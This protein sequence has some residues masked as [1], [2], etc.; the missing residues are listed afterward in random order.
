MSTLAMLACSSPATAPADKPDTSSDTGQLSDAQADGQGVDTI[1]GDDSVATDTLVGDGTGLEDTLPGTD[2]AT[3]GDADAGKPDTSTKDGG[4]DSTGSPQ[5]FKSLL[6]KILGP[7][8]RDW[9]QSGGAAIQLTGAAFGSP[10]SISWTDA[11]GGTGKITPGEYWKSGILTLKPG[12]NHYTVTATKGTATVSDTVH[13]VYNPVFQFDG[14][15]EITPNVLFVNE[16]SNVVVR[17]S[18]PGAVAAAGAKPIIDPATITLVETDEL[19]QALGGGVTAQLKDSGS[20]GDCDDVQKDAVFSECVSAQSSSAKRRYFRVKAQVDVGV[21]QYTAYSPLASIDVVQRFD[22][23]TC[24]AIVSLQKKAK[25]QFLGAVTGGQTPKGAQ[26][27]VVNMLKAEATV[28]EAGIAEDGGYGVW[29]RYKSGQLGALSLAPAGARGASGPIDAGALAGNNAVGARRALSLAP[30]LNEFSKTGGDEADTAGTNLK[31]KQCPPFAVD[32][33][34]GANAYLHFYRSMSS[35]G[36]VAIS[37][38]GD[39]LFG[40]MDPQAYKDLG[41]EHHGAQEV[42]WSGE[43]VNCSALSSSTASCSQAGTGCP[44]GET[45]VKTSVS[46]GICVD[47]TQADIMRGRAIIG[48]TTYGLTPELLRFHIRDNFAQSIVYLGA[49]RTLF[50]GTLA[51]QLRSLGA[52]TVVGF[53]DYVSAQY[54]ADKGGKFFDNLINAG[55]SSASALPT[56]DVDP[57]YGGKL[58]MLGIDESNVN[59]SALINPSWDSGNLTGWKPVGDGRVISRL[60][61]TIPVAGKYMGIISTGLGFTTQNGSLSQPFCV[62]DAQNQLCFYWKFYSEEFKEYCG[63]SFMDTFMATLTSEL[64]KNTMVNVYIDSLCD[65]DCGGKAPCE[66]GSPSCQCG[67]DY[68]GLSQSDVNFDQGGVWMTPWQKTCQ[69]VSPLAGSKKK[70]ELQFF[71]T[72]KG[73]SIF[74]TVILL[75]EVTVK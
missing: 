26:V 46:G 5:M 51:L 57:V 21:Q 55:A 3:S 48:D 17:F 28:A 24:N 6:V 33:A 25:D 54:A 42:I 31:N 27:E 65:P 29:I 49:C 67:K 4:G 15:P 9:G 36:L 43:A 19:G 50:N 71:A 8:G 53:S 44:A 2:D 32:Q 39:A 37:G 14:P 11:N 66:W 45:C 68:K 20:A 72:D 13:I 41:W 69:D 70:V 38:H 35:Y 75:D 62:D 7:T 30:N 74:D 52:A 23:G 34:T 16:N 63:S 73:D 10:E 47:H 64:G 1:A 12:D 18:A 22:K 58:R 60:G 59:N 56:A 40:G 61:V